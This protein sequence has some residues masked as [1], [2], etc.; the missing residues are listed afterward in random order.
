MKD[1]FSYIEL[2]RE[3]KCRGVLLQAGSP[4]QGD[5]LSSMVSF[6]DLPMAASDVP[7]L[8]EAFLSPREK[9]QLKEKGFIAG[10]RNS[11][12]ML[13][14]WHAVLAREDS[15]IHCTWRDVQ[16]EEV[17][18]WEIPALLV[19]QFG[20]DS[21]LTLIAGPSRSGRTAFLQRLSREI[22]KDKR[23]PLFLASLTQDFAPQPG[24][25]RL[26]LQ[27]LSQYGRGYE[28]P[29]LVLVDSAEDS[30]LEIGVRLAEQ[31]N[32]VIWVTSG[33]DVIGA[34]KRL[35]FRSAPGGY[36]RLVEV[37]QSSV[38]LRLIPALEGD[39]VPVLEMIAINQSVK[40]FLQARNFSKAFDFVK[41]GAERSGSRTLNQSLLGY[42]LKR[43]IDLK[44]GFA[45][46]LYPDELDG[47]LKKVGV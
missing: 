8:M 33:S 43:K 5:L 37:L 12:Q 18:R 30:E 31:G 28:P 20:K 40:E 35:S 14:K 24:L 47:M 38:A 42:M 23:Q 10:T 9:S 17:N 6:T 27:V 4:P 32:Q 34:L 2:A 21:G 22:L 3:R 41:E 13:M 26:S 1:L 25:S 36:E 46:S 11:G 7:A 39:L 16:L 19:N 29:G 44:T 45:T 15:F